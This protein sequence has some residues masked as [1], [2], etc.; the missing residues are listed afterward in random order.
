MTLER[1]RPRRELVDAA[2]EPFTLVSQRLAVSLEL[3]NFGFAAGYVSPLAVERGG[4]VTPVRDLVL[5]AKLAGM[6]AVVAKRC[7][8]ASRARGSR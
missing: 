2:G 3:G 6:L 7:S 8:A 1:S 5:L 4:S